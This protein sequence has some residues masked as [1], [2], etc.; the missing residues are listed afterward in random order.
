MTPHAL[1]ITVAIIILLSTL[2]AY[3]R[4]FV[5]EFFMLIGLALAT[6]IAYKAGHL[7]QPDVAQWL[8]ATP[9]N[10]D[11]EKPTVLGLL[12]PTQATDVISYGG[13]F[14]GVFI[15]MIII[16]MMISHWVSGAGLTMADRVGG[17]IFGF[18]YVLAVR[19]ISKRRLVYG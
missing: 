5:R 13:V 9:N 11:S 12:K 14:L 3:F 7:L 4:G 6:F 17:A 10:P 19:A 16:R 8:G 1:D 15:L 2:S 18:V